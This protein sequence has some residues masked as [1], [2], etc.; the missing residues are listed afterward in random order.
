MRFKHLHQRI[1][2]KTASYSEA[3]III[4]AFGDSVT[5]GYTSAGKIDAATVYHQQVKEK[6]EL[7]YPLCTFS[8]I[9]AGAAGQTAADSLERLERDVIRYQPDLVLISFGL[10]D[11]VQSDTGFELKQSLKILIRKIK[12][13][14]K[15]DLILISPNFMVTKDNPN[16]DPSERHYLQ[17]FLEVY[18]K[19][20]L[21]KAV[22]VIR[23][24]AKE[25]HVPLADVYAKWQDLADK[26]Q[27]MNALLANGL[28]HPNREA[29]KLSAEMIIELITKDKV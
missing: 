3:P 19:G 10:N 13:K 21:A 9:N 29:H 23:E 6:L 14:T 2:A 1:S 16:I 27:D 7:H 4:V 26:G 22:Q 17:G 11:A 28:N 15:A 5:Q 24:C 20:N 12:I 8:V 25:A 18:Q